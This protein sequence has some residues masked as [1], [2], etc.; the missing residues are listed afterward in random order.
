[1]L[2]LQNHHAAMGGLPQGYK[3]PMCRD[4]QENTC[5]RT[6]GV[7]QPGVSL[8]CVSPDEPKKNSVYAS[9]EICPQI[10][11]SS[12]MSTLDTAGF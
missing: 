1:M 10:F 9:V 7:H 3:Q 4:P 5:L 6:V 2:T 11:C 12:A 8:S